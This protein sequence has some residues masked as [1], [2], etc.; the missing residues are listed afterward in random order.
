LKKE[1]FYYIFAVGQLNNLEVIMNNKTLGFFSIFFVYTVWGAQPIYWKFLQR[2]PLDQI[3]A[4]RIIWSF[5]LLISIT[6]YKKQFNELLEIFKSK[7]SMLMIT[8]SALLIASN[9][10]LNIYAAYSNQVIEASLG[11]YITPIVVILIGIFIFKDEVN[12][13]EI[14]ATLLA[15]IGVLFL[16]LNIGEMPMIAI[17]LIFTFASYTYLKKINQLNTLLSLTVEIIVLFPFALAYLLSIEFQNKGVFFQ[18]P[19][20]LSLLIIS[21]GAFTAIPLMLYSYGVQRVNLSKLGFIQYYGPTLSLFLG[22]FLF[23]ETFTKTHFISFSFIW[24]AIII[25]IY[26][27]YINRS[28][29]KSSKVQNAS[30]KG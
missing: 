29:K 30:P 2:V 3:L 1:I 6:F 19:S 4:H 9:W 17:L 11:H 27:N 18:S 16:A 22:V 21:T 23:K 15:I 8:F 5:V 28:S 25:V 26:K 7:N 13:Y 10:L 14:I 12:R 24:L 20:S